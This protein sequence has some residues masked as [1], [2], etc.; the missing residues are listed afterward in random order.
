MDIQHLTSKEAFEAL[1]KGAIL[2]DIREEFME[3]FKIFDI[4]NVEY[5]PMS[6]FPKAIENLP[7]GADLIFA[8]ATGVKS[9]PAAEMVAAKGRAGVYN[10]AGG[11]L[12]WE[13]SQL[14][15]KAFQKLKVN[16]RKHCEFIHKNDIK[17]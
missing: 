6:T 15:V 1:Q 16:G 11:L 7:T 8:D 17:K 10:L 9:K 4:E 5:H 2:I 3:H 13:R 12:E 14:P